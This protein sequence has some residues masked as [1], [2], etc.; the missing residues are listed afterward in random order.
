MKN[1]LIAVLLLI[2]VTTGWSQIDVSLQTNYEVPFDEL[3]WVYK[4][5]VNYL[6]SVSKT[7]KYKKKRTAWGGTLGYSSFKPKEDIFYYLVNENEIGTIAYEE[8]QTLQIFLHG[9]RDFILNKN[10]EFF[11]GADIGY[12]HAMF[13]YYSADAYIVEDA[14]NIEGRLAIAPNLGLN[15]VLTDRLGVFIQS[16]YIAS[17]AETDIQNNVLNYS[18]SGGVGLNLR[19]E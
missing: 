17:V 12:I 13:S 10:L 2:T 6:L 4:P 7:D 19:F 8:Y 9:R 15:F 18:L 5:G 11:I 16:R 1:S 3:K 14:T